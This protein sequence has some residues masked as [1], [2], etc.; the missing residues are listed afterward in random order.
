MSDHRLADRSSAK[1]SSSRDEREEPMTTASITLTLPAAARL[2]AISETL[3]RQMARE[4][5][6]P[7]AFQLGRVWRVHRET[8]EEQV[9]RLARGQPIDCLEDRALRRAL[10]ETRFRQ[11]TSAGR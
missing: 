5:R 4:G 11:G 3:A 9:A 6:F 8:F 7:G 2:L 1:F 10:D